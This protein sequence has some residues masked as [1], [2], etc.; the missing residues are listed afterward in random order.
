MRGLLWFCAGIIVSAVGSVYSGCQRDTA[1]H[2]TEVRVETLTIATP[3]ADRIIP[4]VRTVV[5]WLRPATDTVTRRDTMLLTD[6]VLV[7]VPI[8]QRHYSDTT[9]EAWV[10]G[11]EARLDSIRVFQREVTQ[12]KESKPSR[13]SFG[14]QAGYGITPKGFQPYLGIGATVR[15]GR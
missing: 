12:W 13:W 5:K 3:A 14:V 6:S 1:E 10:S 7:E 15:L 4:Q 2:H 9:Y 11:Y 8:A